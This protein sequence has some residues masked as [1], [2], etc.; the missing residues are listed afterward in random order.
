[1]IIAPKEASAIGSSAASTDGKAIQAD[2]GRLS[3][4]KNVN[5]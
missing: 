4:A 3:Y 2:T 1:M 5:K